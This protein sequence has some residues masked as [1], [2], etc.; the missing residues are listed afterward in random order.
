M[1]QIGTAMLN[2]M[3]ASDSLIIPTQAEILSAKGLSE[4]IKHYQV[5]KNVNKNLKIDGILITMDK[6]NT[7]SSKKVDYCQ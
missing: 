2:V 3:V 5:I 6:E 4:L 1:P 7:K